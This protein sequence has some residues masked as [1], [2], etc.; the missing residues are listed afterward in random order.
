[1]TDVGA[2]AVSRHPVA[3][4]AEEDDLGPV[5]VMPADTF[6]QLK[7]NFSGGAFLLCIDIKG[8]GLSFQKLFSGIFVLSVSLYPESVRIMHGAKSVAKFLKTP[9]TFR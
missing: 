7:G 1:M 5:S 8:H 4:D 9:L 6:V 2:E 3:S